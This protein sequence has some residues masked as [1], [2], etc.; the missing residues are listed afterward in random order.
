MIKTI[1]EIF[2]VILTI[3]N[4]QLPGMLDLGKIPQG[5][6]IDLNEF[7]LKWYDEFDGDT[8]DKDKWGF[9]WWITERKGGYWHEDMVSVKDGNL[10]IRAE[11]LDEPLENY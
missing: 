5:K 6:T 10:V 11:Y 3:I 7:E 2:I 1:L 8:L 9:S 4:P